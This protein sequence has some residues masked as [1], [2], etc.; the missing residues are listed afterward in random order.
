MP[1]SGGAP[2][3]GGGAGGTL[4]ETWDLKIARRSL[5]AVGNV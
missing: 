4:T 1:K 5:L 2:D 3:D